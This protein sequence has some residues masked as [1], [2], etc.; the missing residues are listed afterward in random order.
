M[1]E[2]CTVREVKTEEPSIA[3]IQN[4]KPVSATADW[5]VGPGPAIDYYCSTEVLRLPLRVDGGVAT[6]V[7]HI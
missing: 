6:S 5:Q 3:G 7:V 2:F 1:D 4:T